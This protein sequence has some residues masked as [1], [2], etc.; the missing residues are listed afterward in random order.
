MW[1]VFRTPRCRLLHG[2]S[3]LSESEKYSGL[4]TNDIT[5]EPGE[6]KNKTQPN[7]HMYHHQGQTLFGSFQNKHF[8]FVHKKVKTLEDPEAKCQNQRTLEIEFDIWEQGT[9]DVRDDVW[10]NWSLKTEMAC[11]WV[12]WRELSGRSWL[13]PEVFTRG[14]QKSISDYTLP[15]P[16]IGKM[17][18]SQEVLLLS[19]EKKNL[20]LQWEHQQDIFSQSS[21]KPFSSS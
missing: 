20:G 7:K 11:W 3:G 21:L 16:Q 19:A 17:V 9:R 1:A 6:K 2:Y 12:E 13:R 14:E 4:D 8:L 18:E 5:A 15:P 10:L